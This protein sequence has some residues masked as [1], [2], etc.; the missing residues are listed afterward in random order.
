MSMWNSQDTT[1]RLKEGKDGLKNNHR[2]TGQDSWGKHRL[3]HFYYL[4]T[5]KGKRL[6]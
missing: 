1:K 3:N 4:D 2:N 5:N 6:F